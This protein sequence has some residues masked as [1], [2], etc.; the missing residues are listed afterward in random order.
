MFDSTGTSCDSYVPAKGQPGN[1]KGNSVPYTCPTF[2]TTFAASY[3]T[4]KLC[5]YALH[6][7]ALPARD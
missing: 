5:G 4:Y 3:R 6:S 2:S 1:L 7:A